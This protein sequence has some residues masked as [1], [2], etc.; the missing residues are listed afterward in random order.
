V[1]ETTVVTAHGFRHVVVTIQQAWR[2]TL[3]ATVT[4]AAQEVVAATGRWIATG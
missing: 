1:L 3:V 4:A 2:A